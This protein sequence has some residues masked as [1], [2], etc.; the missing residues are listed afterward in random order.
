VPPVSELAVPPVSG[1][2]VPPVSPAASSV[3]RA[4]LAAFAEG[5]Q[6]VA[7]AALE[8]PACPLCGA[9][10]EDAPR[11]RFPPYGVVRCRRCGFWYLN[12]RLREE[13]M[14]DAYAHDSYFEGAGVGYRSYLAQEPTLRLTFRR[15]LAEL[16]A[17]GICGRQSDGGG[18]QSEGAGGRSEGSGGRGEG[19]GG[20]NE[21][22]GSRAAGRAASGRLL[23]IGCAYGFFL[24]EARASFAWCAGTDYSPAALEMAR[25]RADRVYL[26]GVAAVAESEPFD[27]VACIHVVEHVY[28]P[29]RFVADLAARLRPGGW[30]VLATP[31]MAGPWR[32]LMGRRW[33]FFKA[34]EH[35]TYFDRRSLAR[36]LAGCGFAEVQTVPYAGLFSLEMIAEKLGWKVPALARRLRLRLPGTTIAVAARKPA[37]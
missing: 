35:V 34:P 37:A 15:F 21:G 6:M 22:G 28:D 20:R 1:P 26:G 10:A 30:I 23:E 16:A 24:E 7:E 29:R 19:V 36:L 33:P 5:A 31:N 11:Y 9:T 13:R 17:R 4:A 25:A 32:P 18:A 14:R 3:A 27:C 8:R 12:P 2:A